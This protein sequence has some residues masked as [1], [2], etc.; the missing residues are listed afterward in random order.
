MKMT[1]DIG[2]ALPA[3]PL[4]GKIPDWLNDLDSILPDLQPYVR[5]LWMPDHFFW[6]D[7]PTH[8]VWTVL[9]YLAAKFPD[10]EVGSSVLGQSYRNPAMLAK[11]GSTLQTLSDGRFILGIGAGWKE[12]EYLGY[13]YDF[14]RAKIRLEQLDEALQV[15]KKLWHSDGRVSFDGQYYQVKDAYLIPK[16]DPVPP[17]MVGGGGKT[18]MLLTAKYADWWNISDVN[19]DTFN[20]RAAILKNH[21]VTI[22]R[23]FSTMR[24]TWF[25]RLVVGNTEAE[26]RERA[27]NHGRD[28]YAGWTIDGAFVGT[29]QQILA[30][31]QLF[32]DA[33]ID[34]FM[35]EMLEVEDQYVRDMIVNQVLSKIN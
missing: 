25:G 18:T 1:I 23:D 19:I 12:D 26:A 14:P 32:I 4:H 8:E 6:E 5:S 2:M 24:L 28:H 33:G 13:G 27:E 16:P 20:E 7:A 21:C 29:P 31:L 11:M 30:K 35:F 22:G 17:I 34:Y 15:I 10:F 3:G 9:S